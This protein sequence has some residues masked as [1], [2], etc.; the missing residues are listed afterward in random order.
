[1]YGGIVVEVQ[2]AG[3][4]EDFSTKSNNRGEKATV[5]VSQM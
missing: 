5:M 3:L 2:N 1:M 4:K